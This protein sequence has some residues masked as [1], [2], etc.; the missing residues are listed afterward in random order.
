[1]S[2]A[3]CDCNCSIKA[4]W[5]AEAPEAVAGVCGGTEG[6]PPPP[7]PPPPIDGFPPPLP[8]LLELLDEH[9]P[10]GV[11]VIAVESAPL[12]TLITTSEDDE[13]QVADPLALG[14]TAK[15][16]LSADSILA[17]CPRTK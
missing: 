7:P 2:S 10:D 3:I 4:F 11:T 17:L 5:A 8:L 16:L 14:L 12:G 9:V 1:M 13:P 15:L 6:A